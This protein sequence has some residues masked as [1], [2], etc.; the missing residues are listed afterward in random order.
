MMGTDN[1]PMSSPRV[2][3]VGTIV[4]LVAT[5]VTLALVE[6]AVRVITSRTL[7]YNIEMVKYARELQQPDPRGVVS[8]V[9]QPSRRATLMGVD[10]ALNAL[11]DRGPELVEPKPAGTRRVLVLGS[12]VTMGWGVP[13][14]S[15]FTTVTQQRLNTEQPFGPDVRFEFVNAGIGNYSTAFQHELFRAQYP[16]VKP[17]L[18]VLNYFISDVEPR[19]KGRDNLLLKYSYLAAWGFDR[20]SQWQ[21]S[22]QGK[23]LFS[24]YA[25]FYADGAA[26]WIATQRHI[27]EMRDTLA[28]DGVPPVVMIVPDIHDLSAGSPFQPL[29]EQMDRTFRSAGLDVVNTVDAFRQRFGSDVSSLWIQRDDPHP[30]AAGHALLADQL[31]THLVRANPLSLPR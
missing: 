27:R 4:S 18:V 23:D 21:F 14:D 31:V 15:V 28:A 26:P 22:R 2:V 29:Y 9:H 16:L 12:S 30:N 8:H 11:G 20:Y 7:V 25:G 5:L 3:L 10:V 1:T 17:D 19:S 13:F 24:H 6:G